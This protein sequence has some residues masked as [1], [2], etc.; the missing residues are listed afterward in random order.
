[1]V[2]KIIVKNINDLKNKNHVIH[3]GRVVTEL[4]SDAL[5]GVMM[6]SMY[7]HENPHIC[8][9]HLTNNQDNIYNTYLSKMKGLWKLQI[10]EHN[11]E[12]VNRVYEK[13]LKDPDPDRSLTILLN[14]SEFQQKVWRA[15]LQI[16]YGEMRTY[17]EV[18]RDYLERPSA[19]RAL[20]NA[21]AANNIAILVPCHRVISKAVGSMRKYRWGG[22]LK[23]A[24]L[25]LERKNG[26]KS[27]EIEM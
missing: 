10:F 21:V 16:P 5:I 3:Y 25:T 12:L 8:F 9:M 26:R 4:N 19:V 7:E 13:Y 11:E 14:G 6:M 15:L 18:A 20:A 27:Q 24:L 22:H 23:E 1:M 2:P 17:Q